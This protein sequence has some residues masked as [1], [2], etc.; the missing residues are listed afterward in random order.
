M[1]VYR[2]RL[3]PPSE[4][5]IVNQAEHVPGF[6]PTYLGARVVDASLPRRAVSVFPSPTPSR[7]RLASF[8]FGHVPAGLVAELE[9][10]APVLVHAHFGPD[11]VQ[12]EPI[13]RALRVPLVAT[14]HGYDA[15][16]HDSALRAN[17]L[18]SRLY[19][20]R[21]SALSR[22]GTLFIAVSE[23]VRRRLLAQG[24]PADR[25]LTHYIGVDTEQFCPPPERSTDPIV[26]FV[27]RLVEKKGCDYLLDAMA[28]VQAAVP[29][30]QL[31]V[32]GDGPLRESLEK[33]A[34]R[35][36]RNSTFLGARSPMEVRHWLQRARVFCAPSVV[37]PSGDAEGFGLVYAEAQAVGL[38]VAAFRSG[39][40]SEAVA[41]G[42]TGLLA[43][44]RD[45][46]GLSRNI[47][48]LLTSEACW[49][50]MSTAARD[51]VV[52][53]FDVRRQGE[54]LA[55]VYHHALSE[56]RRNGREAVAL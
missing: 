2:D 14:F 18:V 43:N 28:G 48:Q 5:F 54:R 36:L 39:G 10:A 51:R 49:E 40:V 6:A 15:T 55:E 33:R 25:T 21:R 41:H 52:R 44:E 19:V 4:Q 38:P 56:H 35:H 27:G 7:A 30:A 12:A 29:G 26:L 34:R 1:L 53:H 9:L 32:I 37:A 42:E 24:F 13:A 3:L 45:V 17:S 23:F 46:D 50:R 22:R 20:R 8:R 16:L 31:V 11:A 47:L